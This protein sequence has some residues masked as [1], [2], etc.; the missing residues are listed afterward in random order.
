MVRIAVNILGHQLAWWACVLS[1]RADAASVGIGVTAGVVA[2]HLIVS[3]ARSFEV[4]FIPFAAVLGYAVD[5]IA[6]LL[7]AL[8]FHGNP[9][10]ALPT[11]L[12]I[13]ALWLAFATTIHTSVS[14]LNNRLIVAALLGAASGPLAYAAGAALSVVTMPQPAFSVVVLVLLWGGTLPV[15][16]LIARRAA[17]KEPSVGSTA[18]VCVGDTQ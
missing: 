18:P 4:W 2:V 16:V 12:W 17:R 11:P 1:A 9:Q 7:G 5:T 6:T 10:P 13:A 8:Q 14:W 3:P 15:L